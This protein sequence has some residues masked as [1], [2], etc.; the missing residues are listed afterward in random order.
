VKLLLLSSV[1]MKIENDGEKK[2]NKIIGAKV[3]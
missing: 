2:R 3:L 1:C